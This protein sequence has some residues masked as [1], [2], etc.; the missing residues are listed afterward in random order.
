[1]GIITFYIVVRS[2]TRRRE[3]LFISKS[4]F[5][6]GGFEV[7]L[8]LF[9]SL[10]SSVRC[11]TSKL[12]PLVRPNVVVSI[13]VCF[14]FSQREKQGKVVYFSLKL[15]TTIKLLH[16]LLATL[17]LVWRRKFALEDNIEEMKESER[18]TCREGRYTER[19]GIE[20]N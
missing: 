2:N 3:V 8:F 17:D 10:V 7:D 6:G 18:H 11:F 14:F 4:I 16:I 9:L 5:R 15:S 19:L 1:M 20:K 12:G 13:L